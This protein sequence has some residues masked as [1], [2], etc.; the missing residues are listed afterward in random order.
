[1]IAAVIQET[2]RRH[3]RSRAYQ[4]YLVLGTLV[5]I[6]LAAVGTGGLWQK[7]TEL[8]AILLGCQLIGPEFSTGTLQLVLAKPVNRSSYLISR[9][10]GVTLALWITIAA[11]AGVEILGF[12]LR[13]QPIDWRQSLGAIVSVALAAMMTAAMMAFYGSFTRSYGNV[14]IYFGVTIFGNT[15]VGALAMTAARPGG[16][17]EWL[18]DALRTH[19]GIINGIRT[20]FSNLNPD[21]P[22]DLEWRWVLMVVCNSV[23]ALLAA[24]LIFRNREVPYGAD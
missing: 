1:M 21:S 9:V 10:V 18:G 12:L 5:A 2:L 7:T 24:S 8:A 20:F 14:G 6:L 15:L 23:V 22:P 17:L 19:P 11:Q 16:R 13:S 3:L 4:I